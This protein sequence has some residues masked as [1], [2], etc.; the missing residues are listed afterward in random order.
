[1]RWAIIT[2]A[3]LL[4]SCSAEHQLARGTRKLTNLLER[5][6]ELRK[7]TV[8]EA[9]VEYVKGDTVFTPTEADT[10]IY[11]K[12]RLTVRYVDVP[13]PT[14]WIEGECEGDTKREKITYIQPTKVI[15]EEVLYWWTPWLII[16][17]IAA[18]V[19]VVIRKR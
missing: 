6:P 3:L 16:G 18:L 7:D 11:Q 19:L 9:I 4:T 8:I 2:L 12:D 5:Y 1:M 17:L 10:V 15:K 14:V 13:G